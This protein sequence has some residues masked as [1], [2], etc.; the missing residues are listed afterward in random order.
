MSIESSTPLRLGPTV[1]APRPTGTADRILAPI[2]RLHDRL[3]GGLAK[4][5][6]VAE[7]E[8]TERGTVLGWAAQFL[9]G[10]TGAVAAMAEGM[11]QTVRH[12]IRTI[13]GLLALASHV[14]LISPSWWWRVV[15]LGPGQALAED[16]AFLGAVA[17]AFLAP[18]EKD[19]KQGRYFAVAGRAAVDIGT[20][21]VGIKQAKTAIDRWRADRAARAAEPRLVDQVLGAEAR[22]S[23]QVMGEGTTVVGRPAPNG[24]VGLED[25]RLAAQEANGVPLARRT[26][27][28]GKLDVRGADLIRAAKRRNAKP[29]TL[30]DT[31]TPTRETLEKAARS[32]TGDKVELRAAAIKQLERDQEL[33]RRIRQVGPER[34][35]M[36]RGVKTRFRLLTRSVDQRMDKVLEGLLGYKPEGLPKDPLRAA[37]KL[38]NWRALDGG[39]ARLGSL[40]DLARGRIDLPGFDPARMRDMF[41]AIRRHFGE[42]NLIVNDYIVGKPF[43]RGRLHVKI[44]DASGLWYELQIGPK[45]LSQL[46]DTPFTAAGR[47]T[48]V[49]DAVYKGLLRLDDEAVKVLGKGDL[50]LGTARVAKVL[51]QY[52][53]E[54]DDVMKVARGNQPYVFQPQTS[55]LRRGI[56]DLLDE[57][58]EDLLPIGLR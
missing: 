22:A 31:A 56:A 51:D 38:E 50:D 20:L 47:T 55:T 15:T 30:L 48:N 41:K 19:W 25:A 23:G 9:V 32:F 8:A 18:Y 35:A 46:Y 44:R 40:D 54:V 36:D 28:A 33:F 58:P 11:W 16:G 45:Q 13:E 4:L 37:A 14:P 5:G 3:A 21:Y 34:L 39:K 49:H 27:A 17:K 26:N 57:L 42:E 6:Q 1:A 29:G 7:A 12:P 24:G 43:Y 2:D 52:V 53:G 10:A